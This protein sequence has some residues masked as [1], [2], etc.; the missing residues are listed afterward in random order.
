MAPALRYIWYV[1]ILSVAASISTAQSASDTNLQAEDKPTS[2]NIR[3]EESWKLTRGA[4]E[5]GVEAGYAPMQPT[6]FSG[7][8][9][10][11]TDGRRF[12]YASM[13]FGRVIGTKR[14]V[15]Y[16]YL[17]GVTPLALAI[18]N[19]IRNEHSDEYP[20]SKTIRANTY[21]F[22]IQPVGFRFIFTPEKRLKPYVQTSAG[23]IFTTQPIP[24]PQ[25]LTYNFV[26]DF[27]GG[28]MYS[29]T[30]RNVLKAGYR[31][32]HISNMNIGEINPGYNAN[33]LYFDM[34]VFSK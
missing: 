29:L 9:E 5:L 7:K 6:F 33:M 28:M 23:F 12:A 10:Y 15:T 1:A 18:N 14:G 17:F 32:Y 3:R 27:G 25:G 22:A 16:Q 11:D 4:I 30:R 21:G 2:D 24:V 20:S 8:K 34:T 31:Y 26:G 13:K 19:E